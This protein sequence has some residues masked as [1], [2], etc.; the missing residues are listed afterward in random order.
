M[1]VTRKDLDPL[2]AEMVINI[3][4]E[5]YRQKV[6]DVLKNYKKTAS[7]PGFRKGHVP[8]GM[9]KKQYEK[10]VIA[11][12]VNKLLKQE[13]D[14][15]I[16]DEKLD[17]LGGPLPKNEKSSLD[18]DSQTLDFKFELGLAPKIKTDPRIG[19]AIGSSISQTF[20][21]PMKFAQTKTTENPAIS[22]G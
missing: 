15:Y 16:K 18:W 9:I 20:A 2:N 14:R 19:R 13:M 7:I 1:Q 4:K 5:D 10:A 22:A 12:E 21:G 17:L 11:D 3:T 6:D 8:M